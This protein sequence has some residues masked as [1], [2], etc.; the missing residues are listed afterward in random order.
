MT[1]QVQD[2]YIVAATR[3]PVGKAPKG[4]FRNTRPDDMLA[5]VL[6]AVVAQAPGID[7]SRIDDAIIGCAMPE[8][9][10]GMN[11]ARIGVLL[12]GLPNTVAAQTVNR[13]CSSG[14]QAVAL[15]ANEIRLGNADLM[16]AGGT[17]SM[18]MVPMMGNK[19]ALSPQVFAKEENVAIAY[20]MGITAEK[21]AEEW[22][23]SRE[24][25]DAFAVASHQKALKAIAAGEFKQEI[26]PYDIVS[27]MP[28]LA[29]DRILTR[30]RIVDTD[31]GPRA[32]TTLE[33][34][35]K[36]RPV[37]RNGMFGGSVT[38]GNSSQM[39]DGAAGVL[40]A[41]EA[42]IKQYGLTPLA[43]FVSFSVAGVRPEVMGIGPIAAIP[44]ALA[45]AGITQD[46][47]DWIEL[48]EAFA[49]QSL[50]VIRDCGLD[51]SKVNPLGGAIALGHPLGATG[52]IRTAT[53]VH[54]LR[55]HKQKYGMVTMCIGTGM[56]AAGIFEA[57]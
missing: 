7:L 25:Q 24:D 48:N 3:T 49:A 29:A 50:A 55:R 27:H 26:T 15:A 21:V 38:A 40:L 8:G 6:K 44:K 47:L 1:K 2:A 43:R 51:P 17:E 37:F 22:K 41:S 13:F 42:A 45:Q 52:A 20:G 46:Q 32:D 53:I 14:L 54:G 23:I 4:M 33:G 36:L 39:S 28:D 18:S 56:G 16:L 34:L 35:A 9:E 12:A 10:Q 11:V 31:E 5:H 19:V 57:L 30:D